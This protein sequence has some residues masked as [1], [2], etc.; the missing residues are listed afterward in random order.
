GDKRP[1]VGLGAHGLPEFVWCKVPAGTVRLV[2]KGDQ[3]T[4]DQEVERTVDHP[5]F[6]AKTPV[7]LKQFAAFVGKLEGQ[8]PYKEETWWQGL[9]K[10]A[11]QWFHN[12]PVPQLPDLPNRPAQYVSWYQAIAYARWLTAQYQTQR[13]LPAEARVRLPTEWEWQLAATGGNPDYHY[14][15]GTEWNPGYA[16][17][18]EGLNQLVAVGLYPHGRSPVGALDMSG[19]AYEWCLNAFD[20]LD[21]LD[22]T[23]SVPRTTRGGAWF[24]QASIAG[25]VSEALSVFSRLRD[26]ANGQNA[27]G[28]RIVVAIRLVCDV[29]PSDAL[30]DNR[31][32]QSPWV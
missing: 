13:L 15:W 16:S 17:N 24:T 14:P 3:D 27:R 30:V 22:E 18:K 23:G 25:E 29:P 32:S 20:D 8:T 11:D 6:I 10:G 2:I 9:G 19:N 26:N 21:N 1:G 28:D 7:T 31:G 12:K 5:F 4:P